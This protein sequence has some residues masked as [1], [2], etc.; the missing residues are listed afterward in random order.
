MNA[1]TIKSTDT[2]EALNPSFKWLNLTQF[3]GALN[4]NIF[5]LLVTFFLIRNLGADK[6]SMLSGLGGLIFALPFILFIPAAGVLADRYSKSRITVIAKVAEVV[7]MMLGCAIFWF[8][9]PWLGFAVLFLMSTQSAFFGPTKYGIIPE[10]VEPHQLSRANGY[11]VSLSYLSII[12]GTVLAP[13]LTKYIIGPDI[14][15]NRSSMFALASVLCILIALTGTLT[16]LGIHR[17]PA[18]GSQSRISPLFW[19][20]II[21]TLKSIR[22]DRFLVL[23]IFAAS[24]FTLIGA[25]IQ[26]NLIPFAIRH[27]GVSEIDGGLLFLYA[28][29]GIGAGSLLAGRLSGRNIEFG[30]IPI[31]A[32]LISLSTI[33]LFLLPYTVM[34]TRV[35]MFGAGLGAGL[36]IIP[37]EAF[38]QF[39]AP[40]EK[41]GE[42]LAINGFLSWVGVFLAG[43]LIFG[44]SFIPFWEPSYTFVLLGIITFAMTIACLKVLPDF[45]VRFTA[46]VLTRS[47]YKIKTVGLN[48]LP[49]S[50][51]AL[52]VANHVSYMDALLILACQQRRIRFLMDRSIYDGH[53]LK[54][55]FRLMQVIPISEKDHPRQ[56]VAALQQAREQLDQGYLVCI[57]A[58]GA[59][60]R[61]G[62][63]KGFKSGLERIVKGSSHPIIPLHIGGVWGSRFSHYRTIFLGEKAPLRWRYPVTLSIGDPMPPESKAWQVYNAIRE[64][65]VIHF[66]LRKGPQRN[67]ALH[68]IRS[69][70]KN[71]SRVA[72]SDT[73]GKSMSYRKTLIGA[74]IISRHLKKLTADSK[75]IGVVIPPS[76]GGVM[77]NLGLLLAGKIAINLNFTASADAFSSA[78]RQAD[79][80]RVITSRM[81]VEKLPH[82]AWPENLIYAEDLA[83]QVSTADKITALM[84]SIFLPAI[85]LA[86]RLEHSGD[87]LL[88]IMF[89]SGTTGEPKGVMLSHHNVLSNAEAIGEVFRPDHATH[90]C[91]TLPLF[92]SFGFTVGIY[93]PLLLGLRVSYHPSPLDAGKVVDLIKKQKCNTLFTTPSFLSSYYRKAEREELASLKFILV[94]AEK[95][96]K[97]LS[98]AFEEKFGVRPL[99]GYG[100]TEMSP[101]VSLNLP[102]L[103]FEPE[104]QV[105]R[106]DGSIGQPIPG[107]A[108]KIVDVETNQPVAPGES[109]MMMVRGPNRMLGY[110]NRDDLTTAACRDEWYV[111]GDIARVDDDGFIF[112]TDRLFRFSKIGGEMV[113]HIAIEDVLNEALKLVEMSIA[114]TAIPDDKKGERLVLL[115]TEKAGAPDQLKQILANSSLPN[116]WRPA[117]SMFFKVEGLPLT[118]TGK[119]DVKLLKK[120]ATEV[121]SMKKPD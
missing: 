28:A 121:F 33:L 94:G 7:V 81:V 66:D 42:V 120:I 105:G 32:M 41:M 18:M 79:I 64:L 63:M 116:L 77:V 114:V 70:R 13:L 56:L 23:A 1:G 75:H 5:K 34:N 37:L 73:S 25:F 21:R 71:K 38:I 51:G 100:T 11:L 90:L 118:S 15:D 67:V 92:H 108:V 74:L 58:E 46:M 48:S 101:V 112:I 117:E 55:I 78:I 89:S 69:A 87:D 50:G 4:D 39:R 14:T 30:M 99:E 111:T 96:K 85:W 2:I 72:I 103:E 35:L 119:L 93:F 106:K 102:D 110:L 3:Q 8:G 20:D 107:N 104:R 53:R 76:V 12:L 95:L 29:F 97:Q 22:H 6:A 40:A 80:K 83:K 31:G 49:V 47:I 59:L 10:L 109:G 45:L 86:P 16:S 54:R 9:N 61:N 88:T 26:M 98:D 52:L 24:Y 17:T 60:T 43:L 82:L 84:Q 91:A 36:F 68:F 62:Q 65:S 27:L 115:Y 113:P 44:L 57:F 19:R